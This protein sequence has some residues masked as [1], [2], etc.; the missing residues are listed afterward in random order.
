MPNIIHITD[1]QRP[2]LDV[3]LRL[4]ENQLRN[5]LEPEKGVFIAQS[6]KVIRCAL[7]A[8]CVPVSILAEEKH[9]DS[10]VGEILPLCGDIPVYTAPRALLEQITG[11]AL[12]RGILCAMRR[13]VNPTLEQLCA[14][15]RRIAVLD[16]VVDA[17][18]VGAIVRSAAALGMD[19]VLVTTTSCDPL[20]R[21]AVRVSMG[22]LFQ[23]P[24]AEVEAAPDGQQ[25]PWMQ[26]LHA[27]GFKTAAMAL[28]ED[29]IALDDPR[30]LAEEK[31]ALVLGGEGWG[32]PAETIR[33]CDYT[34]TIPMAHGVDS[35]N[36]AAAAA[37]AFWQLRP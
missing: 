33:D 22:T 17:T 10:Q 34:I 16:G 36:V 37:V 21:R 28:R 19:A 8:G 5:R 4:T 6:T 24:W 15:A 18:N 9:L 27:L 2:E 20:N 14:N 13:P 35:L 26:Q 11:F 12:T 3:Y 25:Q 7:D 29:T 31:L 1:L 23:V 30:L 32:L